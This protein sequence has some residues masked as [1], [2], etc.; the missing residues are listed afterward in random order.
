M[1]LGRISKLA[2]LDGK[3]AWKAPNSRPIDRYAAFS[4]KRTLS[5]EKDNST[6]QPQTFF[7]LSI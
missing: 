5:I 7:R 4:E 1:R 2:F 3:P 6:W